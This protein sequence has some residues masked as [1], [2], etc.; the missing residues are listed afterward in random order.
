MA[1]RILIVDDDPDTIDFLSLILNQQGFQVV[2]A[3]SGMEALELA[4][5][6]S[7]ALIVLDIMMPGIDGYEVARSLRRHPE[8]ALIPILMFTAKTQVEDKLAGYESG[9]DIY[10]TKPVHPVE[11]QANIN[12]LLAKRKARSVTLTQKGYL[13]GVLAAKG[14]LGVSTIA[15]NTAITYNKKYNAKVIAAE[16]RPGQGSWAQELNISKVNGLCELLRMDP[17]TISETTV[18][19]QLVVNIHGIKLLLAS[20]VSKDVELSSAVA[21]FEIIIQQ[22]A[23]L[24]KLVML[25][26]GTNFM[27]AFDMICDL[28]DE[29]IVVVE[30]FPVAIKRTHPLL[31]E[32]RS[33][34]FGS[35]KVL[36]LVTLNQ[37]QGDMSQSVIQIENALGQSVAMGFPPAPELRY[38]AAEHAKPMVIMQPEGIIAQQFI[39][40]ADMIEKRAHSA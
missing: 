17:A 23:S 37:R 22:L 28:C 25:D 1:D 21:Q 31:E 26:I 24:A 38:V 39:R 18:D 19:K 10:L 5:S 9:V 7:P 12:A 3:R 29:M 30:P 27:P 14:G 6:Q 15:L 16:L 35:T 36:T 32:L 20:D 13:I 8:T 4:H 2:A 33:K 11:L 34:G 40:L